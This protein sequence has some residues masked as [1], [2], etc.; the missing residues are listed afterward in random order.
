MALCRK[1]SKAGAGPCLRR[2]FCTRCRRVQRRSHSRWLRSRGPT[3][4]KSAQVFCSAASSFPPAWLCAQKTQPD[5]ARHVFLQADPVDHALL[6]KP[7]ISLTTGFYSHCCILMHAVLQIFRRQALKQG[8]QTPAG[9]F[10]PVLIRNL[11]FSDHC[12]G[13]RSRRL[14]FLPTFD[15]QK[16]HCLLLAAIDGHCNAQKQSQARLT[17]QVETRRLR[18]DAFPR[19]SP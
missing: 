7:H 1:V 18:T 9:L 5:G 16:A 15:H 12:G 8:R 19:E 17:L 13:V 10:L 14:Q 6:P 4:F 11:V 3:Q 2:H